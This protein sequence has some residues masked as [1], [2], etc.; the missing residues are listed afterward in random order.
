M[1]FFNNISELL[2]GNG[3]Q[4]G[5]QATRE[6]AQDFVATLFFGQNDILDI[7]FL[8]HRLYRCKTA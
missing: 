7:N 3:F 8:E 2:F 1:S 5:F 4:T 6:S